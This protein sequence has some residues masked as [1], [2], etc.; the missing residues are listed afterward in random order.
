MTGEEFDKVVA[1]V[2]ELIAKKGEDYNNTVALSEY[3]P[4]GHISYVQMEHMKILRAR[5]LVQQ[6]ADRKPNFEG[7]KD[8]LQDLLAYTVFHLHFLEQEAKY[9]PTPAPVPEPK[10]GTW[11]SNQLPAARQALQADINEAYVGGA[12]K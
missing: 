2:R 5:A 7:L 10:Q 1:P 4:F 3:F 12:N 11:P 9:A 6:P 8:T